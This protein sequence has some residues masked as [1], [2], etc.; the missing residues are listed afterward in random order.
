MTDVYFSLPFACQMQADHKWKLRQIWANL[1]SNSSGNISLEQF[2]RYPGRLRRRCPGEAVLSG[3]RPRGW[4]GLEDVDRRGE[5]VRADGGEKEEFVFEEIDQDRD[6]LIE[7]EQFS[8]AV[9][10]DGTLLSL[11]GISLADYD[12]SM[13]LRR[14]SDS[15]SRPLS[16]DLTESIKEEEEEEE[17][18]EEDQFHA[19]LVKQIELS[20]QRKRRSPG[21]RKQTNG[22]D[23][24]KRADLPAEPELK[25]RE[26]EKGRV[27]SAPTSPHG[28]RTNMSHVYASSAMTPLRDLRYKGRLR[29]ARRTGGWTPLQSEEIVFLSLPPLPPSLLS[30]PPLAP[31]PPLFP[32]LFPSTSFL[33]HLRN[34]L[35][36]HSSTRDS[37]TRL[38]GR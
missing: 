36:P 5:G 33:C 16:I 15:S 28:A 14:A 8:R 22:P 1:D 10:K 3:A 13:F 4:Q 23:R 31:F 12:N 19:Q 30:L 38:A 2:M 37:S 25:R 21:E 32:L 34:L 6:G 26:E 24:F 7:F 35:P 29:D 9:E 18:E 11:L 17:E 20:S 27:S